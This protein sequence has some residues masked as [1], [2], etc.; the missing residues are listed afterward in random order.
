M[1]RA[2]RRSRGVEASS[3]GERRLILYDGACGLC[4]RFVR[5]V[6]ARDRRR[7]FLF[8]SVQSACGR[9]V[10]AAHGEESKGLET[11]RVVVDYGSGAPRL[12]ARAA[13]VLFVLEQLGRPWSL[14][15]VF[16]VLPSGLADRIYDSV[17]ARRYRLFGRY[18][19][20]VIPDSGYRDRFLE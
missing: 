19:A 18:P 20:C 15:A 12:L 4:H 13:A 7:R 5:F 3:A 1:T 17:A 10:L 11:I 14:A 8:A 9:S 16:R 6:L 2:S